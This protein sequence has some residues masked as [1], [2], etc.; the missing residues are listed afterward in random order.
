M[1]PGTPFEKR[2]TRVRC[3]RIDAEITPDS[4]CR[5]RVELEWVGSAAFEGHGSGNA[6]PEGRML[7][8]A[9]A[10]IEAL[11]AASGDAVRLELRGAKRVR[12][13]DSLLVIIAVRAS[14]DDRRHDLIGSTVA[15]GGDITRGAVLSVL[16]ATNRVLERYA[17]AAPPPDTLPTPEH[18]DH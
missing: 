7:A 18:P 5:V 14:G 16:D 6:T 15:P 3:R 17:P 9:A 8:G 10:A 11:Q 2:R 4:G 13:F 12:A 1:K